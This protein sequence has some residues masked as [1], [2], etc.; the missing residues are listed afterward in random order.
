MDERA[1]IIE[2]IRALLNM[3]QSKGATEAEAATALNLARRLMEKY[4]LDMAA[5][6]AHAVDGR[7]TV[8]CVRCQ[9]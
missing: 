1:K 7:S 3:E 9:K 4:A 2:R 8:L 6:E 5:V